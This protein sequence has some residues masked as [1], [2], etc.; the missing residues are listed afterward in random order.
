M[1][2]YEGSSYTEEEIRKLAKDSEVSF[3]DYKEYHKITETP[4]EVKTTTTTPGAAVETA[5]VPNTDLNLENTS[6]DLPSPSSTKNKDIS[7]LTDVDLVEEFKNTYEDDG[8]EFSQGTLFGKHIT[9]K[10]PNGESKDF[11]GST[12]RDILKTNRNAQQI[13][14]A[15]KDFA[16]KRNVEIEAFIA[17]N[18]DE[19]A[20]N[21]SVS[22]IKSLS[23]IGEDIITNGDWRDFDA[24][25]GLSVQSI[26]ELS[27]L[28]EEYGEFR[29][30]LKEDIK[31]KGI[32]NGYEISGYQLDKIVNNVINNAV[33]SEKAIK[34]DDDLKLYQEF[35]KENNFTISESQ[36]FLKG[37]AI[38]NLSKPQKNVAQAWA[39]V[40]Q[41]QQRL[42]NGTS[43]SNPNDAIKL[44][45]EIKLQKEKA[46]N[47]TRNYNGKNTK[48]WFEYQ[49]G[50]IVNKSGVKVP[51][52]KVDITNLVDISKQEL[53][54]IKGKDFSLLQQSFGMFQVN[55]MD[56][57]EK[58]NTEK[59]NVNVNGPRGRFFPLGE[60]LSSRGYKEQ[61]GV[62]KDVL[63]KD[64]VE[65]SRYQN[66]TFGNFNKINPK[67]KE[68]SNISQGS[69]S[70]YVNVLAAELESNQATTQAYN[71]VYLMNI[72]PASIERSGGFRVG[73]EENFMDLGVN[74]SE[75]LEAIEKIVNDA[76]ITL[77]KEQQEN[78]KVTLGEEIGVI[79]FGLPQIGI[80]FAAASAATGVLGGL[81]FLGNLNKLQK[82]YT[83]ANTFLS[84]T[85]ALS[86]AAV[87]ESFTMGVVT[88]DPVTGAGFAIAGN[89]FGRAAKALGGGKFTDIYTPLN[90]LLLKPLQ[91]GLAFTTSSEASDFIAAAV[92]QYGKGPDFKT[93]M[94]DKFPD[95]PFFDEGGLGREYITEFLTGVAFSA[96]K[97]KNY[98]VQLLQ[99][100]GKVVRNKLVEQYKLEIVKNNPSKSKL[101]KLEEGISY[102]NS[103]IR[104]ME[105]DRIDSD[106][107]LRAVR[108]NNELTTIQSRVKNE[109]G[110]DFDFEVKENG[111]DMGGKT[112]EFIPGTSR[113]SGK[114]LIKVDAS[115]SNRGKIPHEIVHFVSK[116][117]GLDSPESMGRLRNIIEPIINEALKEFNNFNLKDVIKEK[118]LDQDKTTRPEEYIANIVELLQSEPRIRQALTRGTILGDL[119]QKV[120]SVIERRFKGTPLEGQ[121]IDF[122]TPKEL[123]EFLDRLGRDVGKV[124]S[125]NQIQMFKNLSFAGKRI[126]DNKTGDFVETPVKKARLFDADDTVIKSKSNI[127]YTLP[128]GNKGKLNATQ[129]ANQF[130]DLK[131]SGATFD[132]S[133]FSKVIKGTKGPLADLM[134]KFTE[135][136]GKRDVFILTARPADANVAIKEFLKQGLGIDIPL[137]NIT[138]LGD[139][140]ASAKADWINENILKKGYNDVF[141]ADDV[142]ANVKAVSDVLNKAGVKTRVQVA[143]EPLASKDI[144]LSNKEIAARNEDITTTEVKGKRVPKESLTQA[145]KDALVENNMNRARQLANKAGNVGINLEESKRVTREDF[146]A[147]YSEAL[148]KLTN[149]YDPSKGVPFGAYMN[150]LLPLKYSGILKQFKNEI[151]TQTIENKE[152]KDIIDEG[153]N[154]FDNLDLSIGGKGETK[155]NVRR[156]IEPLSF[157]TKNNKESLV[158]ENVILDNIKDV[159]LNKVNYKTLKPSEKLITAVSEIFSDGSK[160]KFKPEG[161]PQLKD[162]KPVLDIKANVIA[163]KSFINKNAKTLYDMLPYAARMKTDG[164]SSSTGIQPVI[165]RNLYETGSRA[166]TIKGTTAGLKEQIKPTW[167]PKVEQRF[168]KLFGANKGAKPDRNQVTAINALIRETAKSTL[169]SVAR[170]K[171]ITK[172]DIA[173]YQQI[174]DGKSDA[175]ASLDV[176]L[177][178]GVKLTKDYMLAAGLMAKGKFDEANKKYPIDSS[179]LESYVFEKKISETIDLKAE[180]P[181]FKKLVSKIVEK[182]FE[183]K[184]GKINFNEILDGVTGTGNRKVQKK[185]NV[186]ISET[187]N[188]ERITEQVDQSKSW[189]STLPKELKNITTIETLLQ[190][191]GSGTYATARDIRKIGKTSK[192]DIKTGKEVSEFDI[193]KNQSTQLLNAIGTGK[194]ITNAFDGLLDIKVSGIGQQKTAQKNVLTKGENQQGK[195]DIIKK[196]VN[197]ADNKAKKDLYNAFQKSLQEWLYSSKDKQEFI[198]RAK[199]VFQSSADN[200]S[201]VM[202]FGRQFVPV[203]AVLFESSKKLTTKEKETLKVEHL[204]S[205]LKQSFESATAVV[206]GKW[207]K[208][209]FEIMKDYNAVLS[210]KKYLDVID[211]L[212][213]TTNLAG[214][215]RMTLDFENLKKYRT[216]ESDYEKTLYDQILQDASK[217][218]NIDV[219]KLG[220]KYLIDD[221]ALYGFSKS[222]TSKLLLET[223]I[224]NKK[225]RIEVLTKNEKIALKSGIT[226][227]KNLSNIQI[228]EKIKEKDNTNQEKLIESYASKDLNLAFNEI[229]EVKTGIGKEKIYSKAKAAVVGAKSG[230]IRLLASSAQDFEGL[231]YRTLGKGKLGDTQKQFYEE[232]L[233]RP[234]AQAEANLATDRVTMAN[235]FK[236]LKKQLKVSPKDLRKNIEG[237][238]WSKEQ[239]IRVHI[240]DKQGMTIPD[241]SKSD[242][243]LLNDFVKNDPKLEAYANE[244]ILLG[245][246]SDYAAPGNSWEVGTITSDLIKGIQTTKRSQ[247]LEPFLNNV[248]IMFSDKNLNKLEAGFGTKYREALENSIARIRA[249]KNRLFFNSDSGSKLENRVL[250]YINNST[251]TIMFLNTRSAVLQTL[252]AANFLNFKENNPLAAGKAFA[253]QPQYWKDFSKLMNSDYLV[254]RRQGLRLNVAE[255]EIA[256]A[257]HD[258]TNKPKAA[259]SYLLNK[260]FL[261]TKFADSFAIASGGATYYRNRIKM[262]KKQGMTTVEAEKKAYLDFM[263]T[264]EKSQQSSKAQRISMQQASNLGRVVLAFANTPS[265]YLRL[266]QKATSDLLNNRGSKTENISKIAYY[267]M[268]QNILFTTLQQATASILFDDEEDD[269]DQLVG[270][271]PNILSSSFDNLARGA[272]VGGAALVTAKAIAMKIYK[273]SEKKRPKYSET[274]YELLT[275][276]PPLRSKVLKLRSAGRTVEY[277]GGFQKLMNK[278]P[279][280][281]NPAYLA[282]ANV[283]SSFTNI[284]LDRVVK[285]ADNL[286][287]AMDEQNAE[288]QRIALIMGWG[289]W[290]LGIKNKKKAR[291]RAVKKSKNIK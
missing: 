86:I 221:L 206:E 106:P 198:K 104:Q 145:D 73:F 199:F 21:K 64:M 161:G 54:A 129:F 283:V 266:T 114:P 151:E 282:G 32:R 3:E 188:I 276:S 59:Y 234:L 187:Y 133:E 290:E 165:V 162:G 39:N 113:K 19:E 69:M 170:L 218:L 180:S 89:Y 115:K 193:V 153:V 214:R 126:F 108:V 22:T 211:N 47:L 82:G 130:N 216:V 288:W 291:Y 25:E 102:M 66:D 146:L 286:K 136:E 80:E 67:D 96:G 259:L 83:A 202:G 63:L 215:D 2:E 142:P 154:S 159:D 264:S 175:L 258:Q 257:V 289:K 9:V 117:F 230:K 91:S 35:T 112:A 179:I 287:A 143:R 285:K 14:D 46:Q 77:N 173:L 135:A 147:G 270:K 274:A 235:N 122:N 152:V 166:N 228:I 252:S 157:L 75:K 50:V 174:A 246:G 220:E 167:N 140:R 263:D 44:A 195:V 124:G 232:F 58:L 271:L 265:Q 62:F 16:L 241:I 30:D 120:T 48:F 269:A 74:S 132:F 110:K 272:G 57:H 254:D 97:I 192:K 52:D 127:I 156:L 155:T 205:S 244:L 178:K 55:K 15:K 197:K 160:I 123:L 212:G 210:Y 260:G 138:G 105:L 24:L 245:K 184:F 177:P 36:D 148:V 109:T 183:T 196:A 227:V 84:R 240:W 225:Q 150:K 176:A 20:W 12:T 172:N 87:K 17:E 239:A 169:N 4:E 18:Q 242:L 85:K 23:S 194:K 237:E 273:E 253:N 191:L 268:V 280:L 284:P 107:R 256:D 10:A 261:P 277:A 200:S 275:F 45:E 38:N 209:G 81:S 231:M 181:T 100:K 236:G 13:K 26:D 171:V 31:E 118:Y 203:E 222:P 219:K 95:I 68:G 134:K 40:N 37:T 6:S 229:I 137:E 101:K 72:D 111:D 238:P 251:G 7:G 248:D 99:G 233:Y 207:D 131:E 56:L 51:E 163:Q 204:K 121:S 208:N 76:G 65:L 71:D 60:A 34:Y 61:D 262:Y 103:N 158:L 53:A 33:V 27:K 90:Q 128:D 11:Y 49:D 223:A 281:D 41:L 189:A 243:K 185:G 224:N 144:S 139:G 29:G 226:N 8:F 164:L 1:F 186:K 182:S 28:P 116:E 267:S 201:L 125:G 70:D 190:S 168:L 279:G 255:S 247:Y 92:N 5:N 79:G 43:S 249:G 42:A 78:F 217:E 213:G 93:F 119:K 149:T 141:F 278:G 250:D 88:G 94:E 98:D